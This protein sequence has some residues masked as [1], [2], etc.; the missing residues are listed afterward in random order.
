[1]FLSLLL[2]GWITTFTQGLF[3]NAFFRALPWGAEHMLCFREN[4]HYLSEALCPQ[5]SRW[6]LFAHRGLPGLEDRQAAAARP[7]ALAK[8]FTKHSVQLSSPR[9]LRPRVIS[10][11]VWN[12]LLLIPVNCPICPSAAQMNSRRLRS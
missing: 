5:Y 7:N 11:S 3:G 6:L 2:P 8:G 4:P 10:N 9:P 1:M 12:C